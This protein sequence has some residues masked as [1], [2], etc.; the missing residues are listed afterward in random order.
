MFY[1]ILT[2]VDDREVEFW[3][4]QIERYRALLRQQSIGFD[5]TKFAVTRMDLLA[6]GVGVDVLGHE[7]MPDRSASDNIDQAGSLEAWVKRQGMF[8]QDL[9]RALL[10]CIVFK[11]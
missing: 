9:E 6:A 3:S 1:L 10:M 2:S 8:A 11:T 4:Q 5:M 7:D